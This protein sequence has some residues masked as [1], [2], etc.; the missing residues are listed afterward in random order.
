MMRRRATEGAQRV[1][2]RWQQADESPR[3]LSEIPGLTSLRLVI[4]ESGSGRTVGGAKHTRLFVVATAPALF[5]IPCGDPRCEEGGHDVTR[6]IMFQLRSAKT[7]FE[8]SDPCNGMAG[9]APC[10]TIIHYY[11]TATYRTP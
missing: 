5:V 10:G 6:E 9:T 11:V 3:L 7:S 1:A 2:R 4:E 8:G